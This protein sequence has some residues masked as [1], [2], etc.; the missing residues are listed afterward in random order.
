VAGPRAR[1]ENFRQNIHAHVTTIVLYVDYEQKCTRFL[2]IQSHNTVPLK[3]NVALIL[4]N[5]ERFNN[6]QSKGRGTHFAYEY[7]SHEEQD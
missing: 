4:V 3:C 6:C 2:Q 5:C 1:G 7:P